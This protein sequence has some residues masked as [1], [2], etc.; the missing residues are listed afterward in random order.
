MSKKLVKS[1]PEGITVLYK[2][3]VPSLS[4]IPVKIHAL[5]FHKGEE[6]STIHWNTPKDKLPSFSLELID[7]S[8]E[9]LP[10]M[11]V[12]FKFYNENCYGYSLKSNLHFTREEAAKRLA[13]NVKR[14]WPVPDSKEIQEVDVEIIK[15]NLEILKS[16][17]PEFLI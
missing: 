7:E 14:V 10:R 2:S 12:E 5:H 16:E 11:A 8:G 6:L 9:I 3:H 17:F 4:I 1:I 13:K 15:S